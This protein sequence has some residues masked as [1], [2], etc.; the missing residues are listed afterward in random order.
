MQ[1]SIVQPSQL[2]DFY[3]SKEK[4]KCYKSILVT[5]IL[6]T[7]S[8]WNNFDDDKIKKQLIKTLILIPSISY[9]N[10]IDGGKKILI[11]DDEVIQ[12][13]LLKLIFPA[14]EPYLQWKK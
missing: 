1:N 5:Y 10:S 14:E 4:S 12:Q 2:I 9:L 7:L 8:N 3:E 13:L 11:K 6:P